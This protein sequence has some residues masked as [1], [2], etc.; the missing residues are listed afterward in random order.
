MARSIQAKLA[1]KITRTWYNVPVRVPESFMFVKWFKK[2]LTE[3][4]CELCF[5]L[6]KIPKSAEEVS[7]KS[8]KSV[9]YVEDTLWS[10]AQK[11]CIFCE[12]AGEKRFY[13][14]ERW[15][16]GIDEFMMGKYMDKE[17][18]DIFG[19]M[20]PMVGPAVSWFNPDDGGMRVIP[21]MKEIAGST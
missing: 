17:T 15:A 8:G 12:W 11:G 16:P 19:E 14:L 21:V 3:E 10:V 18:A 1:D 5:Y 6:D 7:E 2:I 20:L 4:E 13:R 9:Q